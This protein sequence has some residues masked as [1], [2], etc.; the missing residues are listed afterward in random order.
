MNENKNQAAWDLGIIEAAL[1]KADFP[2]K[3][4]YVQLRRTRSGNLQFINRTL[5]GMET[6]DNYDQARWRATYVS[7]THTVYP[8]TLTIRVSRQLVTKLP[9]GGCKRSTGVAV[10]QQLVKCHWIVDEHQ[11]VAWLTSRALSTESREQRRLKSERLN[12]LP[13]FKV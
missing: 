12:Q 9:D 4:I 1:L 8:T 11:V 5:R 6:F 7:E 13:I 10:R 2:S 3:N